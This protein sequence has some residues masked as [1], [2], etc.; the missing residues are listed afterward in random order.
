[1]AAPTPMIPV[2]P[3][4]PTPEMLELAPTLGVISQCNGE[5]AELGNSLRVR[6][7]QK[8]G[9]SDTVSDSEKKFYL[10]G[11]VPYAL[12]G[13]QIAAAGAETVGVVT[14][15]GATVSLVTV[16]G[17]GL[18]AALPAFAAAGVIALPIASLIDLANSPDLLKD[19]SIQVWIDNRYAPIIEDIPAAFVTSRWTEAERSFRVPRGKTAIVL[20]DEPLLATTTVV[21]LRA[22]GFEVIG[23]YPS[24]ET[25]I[26]AGSIPASLYTIDNSMSGAMRGVDCVAYVAAAAPY[27]IIIAHSAA[28]PDDPGA[29]GMKSM[30]EVFLEDSSPDNVIGGVEKDLY[31]RDLIQE[32]MRLMK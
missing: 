21:A 10:F 12:L 23:I 25:W 17:E 22:V 27:A 9:L 28:H 29:R 2:I 20:E 11:V 7:C 32:I 14:S 5:S 13:T 6:T 18:I 3:E 24:C 4:T 16:A 19:P 15:T 30:R 31:M 8:W 1:M 26:A